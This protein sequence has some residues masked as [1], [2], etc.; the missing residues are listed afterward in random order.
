MATKDSIR[1][2][3]I[4]EASPDLLKALI[5][6]K[7]SYEDLVNSGDCGSWD[8]K[9]DNCIVYAKEAINKALN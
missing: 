7:Q 1:H 9:Q 2:F 6:L 3:R 8:P 4:R 5:E